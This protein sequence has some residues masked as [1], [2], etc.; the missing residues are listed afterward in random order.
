MNKCARK[1]LA[2]ISEFLCEIRCTLYIELLT[3][4]ITINT[5]S[6]DQGYKVEQKTLFLVFKTW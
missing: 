2:K 4:L 5:A 3:F 6:V 1:N